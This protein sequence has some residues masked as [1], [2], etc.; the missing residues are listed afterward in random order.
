MEQATLDG[1][2]YQ[3]GPLRPDWGPRWADLACDQCD[4]TW[5]GPIGEPCWYCARQRQLMFDYQAEATLT[6]PD[7]DPDD[8]NYP[9]ALKAWAERMNTAVEA[10]IITDRDASGAYRRAVRHE[11]TA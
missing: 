9:K 1:H 7:T 3:V 6:S 4:A 10:G 11:R 2:G 5:T 8:I